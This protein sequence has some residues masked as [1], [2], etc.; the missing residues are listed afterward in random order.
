MPINRINRYN[1]FALVNKGNCL[2]TSGQYE[3]VSECYPEA[4][5]IEATCS[6]ALHNLALCHKRMNQLPE[7]LDHFTKLHSIIRNSPH[8]IY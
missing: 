1:P 6:E 2:F 3:K 4:L 5:S 7:A 8:V